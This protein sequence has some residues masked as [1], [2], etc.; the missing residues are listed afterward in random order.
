MDVVGPKM[1]DN[2][3]HFADSKLEGSESNSERSNKIKIKRKYGAN[4]IHHLNQNFS[5]SSSN[6]SSSK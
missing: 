1:S 2:S 5:S 4:I 6:I 3:V